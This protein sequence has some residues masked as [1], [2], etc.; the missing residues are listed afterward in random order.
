[1]NL[2]DGTRMAIFIVGFALLSV[3]Y[4]LMLVSFMYPG[5]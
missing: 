3:G 4:F 5:K 1:M 2:P